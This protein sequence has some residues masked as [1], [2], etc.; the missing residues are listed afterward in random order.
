[1]KTIHFS[2]IFI[3]V[4]VV[5]SIF[6]CVADD[7]YDIPSQ[8]EMGIDINPAHIISIQTLR[9]LLLQEINTNGVEILSFEDTPDNDLYIEGFVISN[10]EAGNFFEEL[11]LQNDSIQPNAG[12]KLLADVNPLF[13]TYEVGRRVFVKLNG[14][15]VGYD[16]GVLALGFRNRNNVSKIA[17]SQLFHFLK[18]DSVVASIIPLELEI[19][20]LNAAHTNLYIRLADVQFHRSEVLGEHPKTFAAEPLDVFDG[21]RVLESC[22]ESASVIFSTSTFADF[23]SLLLPS[24]R[25]T[26]DGILTYNFFGDELNVVVNDPTGIVFESND[27][28]DPQEISC[29]IVN[30][31]GNTVLFSEFFEAQTIGEAIN[32]NGWT[33]YIEAGTETWEAFFDDGTNASLGISARMG[34]FGSGD[35]S[36]IGWLITPQLNFDIQEGETLTFKTSNSFSDA[37]ILEVVFSNDWDGNP[38]HIALSSWSQLSD[39]YVVHDDDFFGDWFPSGFVDLSCLSGTGYIAWRYTGSGDAAN[40]GTYEL[41][42]IEIRSD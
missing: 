39:A 21:E 28:C 42:E 38:E 41:D 22:T 23:K 40:D 3:T 25:G 37:S 19:H 7:A 2:E 24:G 16:S 30:A 6:S 29:G 1:M 34:S 13:T 14:L 36:S 26:L 32:G 12:V 9:T 4:L 18:R 20:E 33:N 15:S 27:R 17:E 5:F 8:D 11:I 10:D 31:T 35:D